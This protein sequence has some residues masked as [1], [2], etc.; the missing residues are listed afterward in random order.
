MSDPAELRPCPICDGTLPKF[1]YRL[2]CTNCD[3]LM[4]KASRKSGW[5]HWHKTNNGI[6]ADPMIWVQVLISCPHQYASQSRDIAL[7]NSWQPPIPTREDLFP[8]EAEKTRKK[9]LLRRNREV[10]GVYKE[11]TQRIIDSGMTPVDT[12]SYIE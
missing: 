1:S 11:Q 2:Y 3:A 7:L 4:K 10:S 12:E 6:C 8:T 5:K 9:R